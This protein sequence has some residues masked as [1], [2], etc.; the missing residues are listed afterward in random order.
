VTAIP[1]DSEVSSAVGN[2]F[3]ATDDCEPTVRW[4]AL[5]PTDMQVPVLPPEG[6]KYVSHVPTYEAREIVEFIRDVDRLLGDPGSSPEGRIRMMLVGYCHIMESEF[7][8]T[9]I[10]NQLRLLHRLAPSWR[11]TRTTK[12][13]R[14][15]VCWFPNEKYKEIISLAQPVGQPIGNIV[16]SVWNANLRNI[17]SHSRYWLSGTRVLASGELSPISRKHAFGTGSSFAFNEVEE[18]YRA[19]KVLMLRVA[20]EHRKGID[21]F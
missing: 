3:S 20:E 6:Q 8:P 10:W 17:F 19:A 5:V 7:M 1:E 15:E 16:S 13:G 18:Y 21:T 12:K 11:F 4:N 9:L 2:L 14:S